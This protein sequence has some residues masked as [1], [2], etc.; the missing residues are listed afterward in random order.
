MFPEKL[1]WKAVAETYKAVR[2]M[3]ARNDRSVALAFADAKEEM[4]FEHERDIAEM[5][6]FLSAIDER[7]RSAKEEQLPANRDVVKAF[8]SLKSSWRASEDNKQREILARAFQGRFDRDIYESGWSKKAWDHAKELDYPSAV[9]LFRVW[10]N[11][12]GGI[13]ER[14]DDGS[15]VI[16]LSQLEAS[17]IPNLQSF[18]PSRGSSDSGMKTRLVPATGLI[19]KVAEVVWGGNSPLAPDPATPPA[20]PTP[21]EG[22]E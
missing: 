7:W 6:T 20:D 1:T 10:K 3:G 8:D 22:S 13:A 12:L 16:E 15:I 18:F 5:K 2:R 19:E 9:F 4:L 11:D 17:L 21:A 14:Q